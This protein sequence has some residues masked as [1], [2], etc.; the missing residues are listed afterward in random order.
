MIHTFYLVCY[1]TC[2]LFLFLS[3]TINTL[4]V[5]QFF[6]LLSHQIWEL[7]AINCN[8]GYHFDHKWIILSISVDEILMNFSD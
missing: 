7:S 3:M 1:F 6:S 8:S 5:I 4:G 2:L